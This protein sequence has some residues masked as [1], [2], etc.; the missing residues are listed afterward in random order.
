M[1]IKGLRHYSTSSLYRTNSV[2]TGPRQ[3]LSSSVPVTRSSPPRTI[4][5]SRATSGNVGNVV[6]QATRVRRR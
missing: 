3:A 5:D 6:R 4:G 1:V 2:G